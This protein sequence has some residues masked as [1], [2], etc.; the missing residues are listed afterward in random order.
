MFW[1]ARSQ[2][3]LTWSLKALLYSVDLQELPAIW[4]NL[5][6]VLKCIYIMVCVIYC[7]KYKL[8]AEFHESMTA[9]NY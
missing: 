4:N 9:T 3:Q 5:P 7:I 6:N 1:K 2:F 8:N